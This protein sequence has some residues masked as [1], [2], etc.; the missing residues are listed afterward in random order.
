MLRHLQKKN[1]VNHLKKNKNPD[2]IY[3]LAGVNKP[4]IKKTF[5]ID[6]EELTRYICDV[7]L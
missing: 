7:V 1:T 2:L 4:S 5:K 6:N 3:H